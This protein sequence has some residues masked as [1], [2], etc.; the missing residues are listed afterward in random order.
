MELTKQVEHL[1]EKL[2]Q[3]KSAEDQ[4]LKV[5]SQQLTEALEEKER[6]DVFIEPAPKIDPVQQILQRKP[7][8]LINHK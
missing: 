2:K 8:K 3:Q 1:G 6:E 4:S 7:Q 5:K